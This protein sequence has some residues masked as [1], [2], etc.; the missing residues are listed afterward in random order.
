MARVMPAFDHFKEEAILLARILAGYSELEVGLMY[1]I[2][3][4]R[5]DFDAALKTMFRTR[6][7]SQRI[8]IAD[9]LGR[10]HYH[11]IGIGTR[12]EMAIGAIKKCLD[13]RNQYAHCVWTTK[14]RNRLGFVN[15][16]EVAVKRQKLIDLKSLETYW[17]DVPLLLEQCD[18]FAYADEMIMWCA[19]EGQVL[20]QK[21]KDHPYSWPKELKPPRM[22]S[23]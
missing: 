19:H 23:L 4:V 9:A 11:S 16:E 3:R 13:I 18:Y 21:L 17:V 2:D 1:S 8:Q 5:S 12:F 10:N 6:G 20:A 7:E 15:L 22:H 14:A